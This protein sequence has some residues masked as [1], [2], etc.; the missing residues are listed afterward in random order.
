MDGLMNS[1]KDI[2]AP[3]L[4][5]RLLEGPAGP[6]MF[7]AFQA[8]I[9]FTYCKTSGMLA[10]RM[11][12]TAGAFISIN[13]AFLL[14]IAAGAF[15][16]AIVV[17]NRRSPVLFSARIALAAGVVTG[18][19][20]F[21]FPIA[22]DF[23]SSI[24]KASGDSPFLLQ[25]WKILFAFIFIGPIGLICGGAFPAVVRT[26]NRRI[27]RDG[28]HAGLLV[29]W[30]LLG[31]AAGAA[32]DYATLGHSFRMALWKASGIWVFIALAMNNFARISPACSV[33]DKLKRLN[34]PWHGLLIS[35][36]GLGYSI[37]MAGWFRFFL[38]LVDASPL[39]PKFLCFAALLGAASGAFFYNARASRI[40]TEKEIFRGLLFL[41]FLSAPLWVAGDGIAVFASGL[42]P[43]RGLDFQLVSLAHCLTA[44]LLFF[45]V[46]AAFGNLVCKFMNYQGRDLESASFKAGAALAFTAAG[47]GAGSIISPLII[48]PH[49]FAERAIKVTSIVFAGIPMLASLISFG[50]NKNPGSLIF[51]LLFFGAV[52]FLFLWPGPGAAWKHYSTLSEEYSLVGLAPN[53]LT[54]MLNLRKR[55]ILHQKDCPEGSSAIIA[56]N[57]LTFIEN[58]RV[59]G[60]A[61]LSASRD[62]MLGLLGAALVKKPEN[63]LVLG[64][65]T[66]VAAG[67][68]AQAPGVRQVKIVEENEYSLK[69]ARECSEV[70]FSILNNPKAS[71]EVSGLRECLANSKEEYDLII[72]GLS[73]GYAAEEL[74]TRE[75]YHEASGHL[76]PGGLFCFLLPLEG[77]T[78]DT[79]LSVA[80]AVKRSFKEVHAWQCDSRNLILICSSGK[81]DFRASEL[82]SRLSSPVYARGLCASWGVKGAEGLFSRYVSG[83]EFFDLAA[84]K[85]RRS[86]KICSDDSPFGGA[87]YAKS[88]G[89]SAA[90][91]FMDIRKEAGKMHADQPFVFEGVMDWREIK[92]LNALMLV[93]EDFQSEHDTLLMSGDEPLLEACR[94]FRKK[95]YKNAALFWNSPGREPGQPLEAAAAAESLAWQNNEKALDMVKLLGD[96]QPAVSQCILARYY[97][98]AGKPRKAVDNLCNA[99]EIMKSDPRAWT[100]FI[101]RGLDLAEVL[102]EDDVENAGKLFEA[103]SEP[104][105]V[106]IL[107]ERRLEALLKV[108]ANMGPGEAESVIRRYGRRIPWTREFLSLRHKV[109]KEVQAPD[110]E[111][112]TRDLELF[113]YREPLLFKDALDR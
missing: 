23:Y 58:G 111:K 11:G 77:L 30:A 52:F 3:N 24:C 38:P 87:G 32:L 74:F 93:R 48:E 109:F 12:S 46:S 5:W 61:V 101:S 29:C 34:F 72:L 56:H 86:D 54:N 60:N 73:D 17:G 1:N 83:P 102:A 79:G 84:K 49:I 68:L 40:Q 112:A 37:I 10:V 2:H 45:P 66:G 107:E 99:F 67:W 41:S 9:F 64:L 27:G 4:L 59:R 98:S 20:P 69:V 13:A 33:E 92:S 95:D 21:L 100:G 63:A 97:Y 16:C 62:I 28:R 15:L 42:S 75:F 78:M 25:L 80:G 55:R 71:V 57:S 105:S 81:V 76:R 47:M 19:A 35:A 88:F 14:S 36:T 53:E 106:L 94:M 31:A 6:G 7:F 44:C 70:N 8:C 50:K 104:F 90:A 113:F 85:A 108:A 103:L 65:G 18:L 22:A 91:Q 51:R 89:K 43:F 110:S 39:A 26:V 82:E 96:F